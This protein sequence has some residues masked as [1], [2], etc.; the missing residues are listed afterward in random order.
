MKASELISKLN[1]MIED[2]GDFDVYYKDYSG[3]FIKDKNGIEDNLAEKLMIDWGELN[4]TMHYLIT[5]RNDN[6]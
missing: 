3:H 2:F 4:P 5:H 1:R 6:G